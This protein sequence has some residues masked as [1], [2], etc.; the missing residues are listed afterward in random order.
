MPRMRKIVVLS[1]IVLLASSCAPYTP[2]VDTVNVRYRP[3]VVVE[4]VS[5]KCARAVSVTTEDHRTNK[6]GWLEGRLGRLRVGHAENSYGESIDPHIAVDAPLEGILSKAFEAE[7]KARGFVVG[8]DAGIRLKIE[9][10][11]FFA[12]FK[13]V[14]GM[15]VA[16]ADVQVNATLLDG[17]RGIVY[18]RE[19]SAQGKSSPSFWQEG[20]T[21]EVA[22]NEALSLSV[23]ALF[24]DK[25]FIDALNMS[26]SGAC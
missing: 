3:G 5:T 2:R 21:A 4:S 18:K 7:L 12:K 1:C 11:K 6:D 15:Y 20:K 23:S 24:D 14:I 16:I 17:T 9:I 25:A 8:N 22:L 26:V 19:F 13:F 10:N